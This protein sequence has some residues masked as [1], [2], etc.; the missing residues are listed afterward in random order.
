MLNSHLHSQF[1][2]VVVFVV[3]VV[4]VALFLL[5]QILSLLS[6]C[7]SLGPRNKV[8]HPAQNHKHFLQVPVLSTSGI[9]LGA[10][11]CYCAL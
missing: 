9:Y 7:V 5:P 3:L 6:T 8:G 2:F 1:T 10:K 11:T 4:V